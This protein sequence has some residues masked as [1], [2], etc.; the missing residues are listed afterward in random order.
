MRSIVAGLLL[1]L[2]CCTA[3]SPPP[4]SPAGHV[5]LS[6]ACVVL[7]D[8]STPGARRIGAWLADEVGARLRGPGWELS[9]GGGGDGSGAS[10]APDAITIALLLGGAPP[11]TSGCAGSRLAP[12]SGSFVLAFGNAT[13]AAATNRAAALTLRATDEVGLQA[14]AGRL[15][16]ELHMPAREGGGGGGGGG[17][18]GGGGLRVTA[19][20]SLCVAHD[21]GAERWKLRGHQIPGDHHDLQFRTGAEFGAYARD[22]AAFGTNLLELSHVGSAPRPAQMAAF[23]DACAAAGVDASVWAGASVWAANATATRAVFARM[24]AL[25]S[26]F[27][28]G[29]DG[30]TL[31][32]SVSN[33]PPS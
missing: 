18:G 7:A 24:G 1:S 32:W 19:P 3:L 12:S 16:R 4:P 22:L 5:D 31:D 33:S 15:L 21:G 28:P 26:V 23:S 10:C 2:P 6:R 17:D 30:G 13:T 27:L 29:G 20:A 9:G 11:N 14:G 25:T 8:A